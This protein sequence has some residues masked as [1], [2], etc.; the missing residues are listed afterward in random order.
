VT[1]NHAFGRVPKDRAGL[2]RA[3]GLW[4]DRLLAEG[5]EAAAARQPDALAVV[6]NRRRL[7]YAELASS[8]ARC[9][10]SVRA[11]GVIP[12]AA[13]V[14]V[15]GNTV[16]GVVA[17]H[18]LLR[19]GAM[20]V[21]LDRRCGAAEVRI[22]LEMLSG[23]AMV[24]VPSAERNRLCADIPGGAP[25]V[26]ESLVGSDTAEWAEP[27]RD[28]P[29]VVL[30]TSGTTDRPKGVIH[31]VN[32]LTAGAR[33]M[34][35]ITGGGLETVTFL[36]SP[37]MSI[38]G[39]MQMHL[40]ADQHAAL[41]LEDRFEAVQSL[42]RINTVGATLLGGAPVIAERLLRAAEARADHRIGLRTLALG[43]AMLPRQLLEL[44]TDA[45]GIEIARLYG[46]SEAPCATG[47]L[48][49]D[50]RE[51]RL[52]DDGALMPGTEVLV[53]SEN[54]PQEGM[55]RGP[56]V[57]L[58]Y[59]HPEDNEFAF[60]NG[61]YRTGDLV[62][63]ETGRLTVVGRLKEVVNRNG[64]KIA[65]GEVESALAG[66]SDVLEYACF[67]LPDPQ[68]GERLAVAMLPE[69]GAA[70]T[71]DAVVAHLLARGVAR[72]RLPEQLVLWDGPLPRTTSGK[73]I[74]SRLIME[75][76]G[77]PTQLVERLRSSERS[78]DVD[79]G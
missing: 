55:L 40:F 38:T 13:A 68:T 75:A 50:D 16:E 65:L 35:T 45:F 2:Y 4:D 60:E 21:V 56:C 32:T 10:G 20:T 64:L 1:S 7:N 8:I 3:Q 46:S 67:A 66:M 48:P 30:F 54:H 69:P 5:I 51:R 74:R 47:S 36:V 59:L 31:S 78:A 23:P 39:I 58:G 77:R 14:L 53:G 63:V 26:L 44:A 12:G 18:A 19:A 49:G 43:G 11:A 37:L 15:A 33:N 61:W 34:A 79:F 62:E 22:A 57:F 42:E 41:V 25:V 70:L 9:V 6:D 76:P 24:I 27:D 28:A 17:Y 52:S 73:V 29:A 71:L 72:R